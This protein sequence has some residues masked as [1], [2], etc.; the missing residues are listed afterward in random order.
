[1]GEISAWA[2]VV[3]DVVYDDARI[4]DSY[5]YGDLDVSVNGLTG[6]QRNRGKLFVNN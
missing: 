5:E 6:A 4:V 2:R 1:M 3:E